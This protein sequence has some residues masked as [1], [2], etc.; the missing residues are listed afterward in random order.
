MNDSVIFLSLSAESCVSFEMMFES[1]SRE[2]AG[3]AL[4]LSLGGAVTDGLEGTDSAW[5]HIIPLRAPEEAA[6]TAGEGRDQCK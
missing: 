3:R 6:M 2:V 5:R 1:K 4:D